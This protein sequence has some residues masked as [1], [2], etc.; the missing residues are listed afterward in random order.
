MG[1]FDEYEPVPELACPVC[2]APL[3][4]WQGKCGPNGLFVWRQGVSEATDQLATEDCRIS[5]E[6]RNEWCLPKHFSIYSYDCGAHKPIYAFCRAE[7]GVWI[8]A[9]LLPYQDIGM[10]RYRL[11]IEDLVRT[12][13][14]E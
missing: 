5:A 7:D 12:K 2:S 9:E 8:T 11:L 13:M 6:A 10:E 3:K 1:M 14:K 4:R